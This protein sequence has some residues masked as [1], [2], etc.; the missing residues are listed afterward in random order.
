LSHFPAML[1]RKES[2]AE[3]GRGFRVGGRKRLTIEVMWSISI[4]FLVILLLRMEER[5]WVQCKEQGDDDRPVLS[6]HIFFAFHSLSVGAANL[7]CIYLGGKLA[8]GPPQTP[9]NENKTF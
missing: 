9:L 2:R 8:G 6:G 3:G 5:D 4:Y 7:G 1:Q